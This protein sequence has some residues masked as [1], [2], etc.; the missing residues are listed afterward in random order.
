[1]INEIHIGM[2]SAIIGIYLVYMSIKDA[3]YGKVENRLVS[4]FILLSFVKFLFIG[5][6]RVETIVYKIIT[7]LSIIAFYYINRGKIG[8]ADIKILIGLAIALNIESFILQVIC[9][10]LL[11]LAF[12][13]INRGIK[14]K[15]ENVRF[16]PFI[17]ISYILVSNFLF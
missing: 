9:A 12:I 16:V 7:V 8:G 17:A 15:I 13:G 5:D 11:A 6:F 1:M 4:V 2:V 3:R 10:A 14:K